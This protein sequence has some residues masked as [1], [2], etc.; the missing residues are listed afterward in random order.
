M[1]ETELALWKPPA[2]A[3]TAEEE[4]ATLRAVP[5]FKDLKDSELKRIMKVLH[6]REYAPGEVVFREGQTGAGMYIIK[7]GSV[8]I[9]MHLDD[10]NEKLLVTLGERQFFGEL[11]LLESIARTA[12]SVVRKPTVLLGIFQS[13]L[14]HLLD[15]D[16][17]LGARIVWNLARIVG[18]RLRELS[19]S[20]RQTSKT[21]PPVLKKPGENS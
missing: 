18:A 9:V 20:V 15:R 5:L 13:D 10:G 21:T 14:E 4:L 17:R 7:S 12:S 6:V 1:V 11:A 19:D 16:S 2:S 8:D 3:V